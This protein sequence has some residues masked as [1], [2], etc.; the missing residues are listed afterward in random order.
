MEVQEKLK[1]GQLQKTKSEIIYEK[2]EE[3]VEILDSN[4]EEFTETFDDLDRYETKKI[5]IKNT[6]I[7]F[8]SLSILL[9]VK[10]FD[11]GK[12]QGTFVDTIIV[13]LVSIIFT[14]SL[15]APYST[16]YSS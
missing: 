4:L 11:L 12:I 3:I 14:Y 10:F 2:K 6:A 7:A 8:I 1:V 13:F 16:P 9:Y 5:A 15:L